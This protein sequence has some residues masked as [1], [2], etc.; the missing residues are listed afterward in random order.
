MVASGHSLL[1]PR[2]AKLASRAAT[3]VT[4][5]RTA[6]SVFILS[7]SDSLDSCDVVGSCLAASLN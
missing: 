2:G 4:R 6:L 3:A 5:A 1:A 7:T